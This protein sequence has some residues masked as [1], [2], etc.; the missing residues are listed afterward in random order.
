MS[1]RLTDQFFLEGTPNVTCSHLLL[2]AGPAYV[3]LLG[4]LSRGVLKVCQTEVTAHSLDN[5]LQSLT[6]PTGNFLLLSP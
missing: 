5:L 2:R 4:A 1:S 6:A 3:P